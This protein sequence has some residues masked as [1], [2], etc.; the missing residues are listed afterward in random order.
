MS[1]RRYQRLSNADRTAI[2]MDADG[3][4]TAF[5]KMTRWLA[6]LGLSVPEI[7]AADPEAGLILLEDLGITS[8]KSAMKQTPSRKGDYFQYCLDILLRI[9]ASDANGLFLNQP[10]ASDL[11]AWT[12]L[13]DEHLRGIDSKGLQAFRD[14]LEGILSSVLD[15]RVTVAL[16]D[17]HSEN[18]MW[19]PKRSGFRRLGLLDYQDAFLTHPAYDLV[20]LLTDARNVVSKADRLAICEQYV[21]RS[22]DQPEPF[23]LAFAALSAQ[24]NLRILGIFARAG[25]EGEYMRNTFQYLVE[26]LEHPAFD[27]VREETMTALPRNLTAA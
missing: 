8:M 15:S 2:L 22:G 19:L 4:M 14:T 27:V 12:K 1:S 20:S 24:R 6:G 16:R 21:A 23:N 18:V 7:L 26:A 9:R 17:F 13:A 5:V 25:I 10:T 11:V 3:D